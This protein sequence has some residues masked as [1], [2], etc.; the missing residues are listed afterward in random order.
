MDKKIL[1]TG[2]GGFIGSHL[3]R[4]LYHQGNYVRIAD[5][6]FDNYIKAH[7]FSEKRPMMK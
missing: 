2:G 6:K 7:A 3:A 1:V 4:Y 5:T